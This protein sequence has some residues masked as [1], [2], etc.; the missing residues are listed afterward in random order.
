MA[1]N[2]NW[3]F[4]WTTNYSTTSDRL[5][6]ND[7]EAKLLSPRDSFEEDQ[8]HNSVDD[9]NLSRA[10]ISSSS[11][12]ERQYRV[13]ILTIWTIYAG[14]LLLSMTLGIV[15]LVKANSRN[16]TSVPVSYSFQN[17]TCGSSGEEAV[18]N[19]CIYSFIPG[20]WVP[21]ACHD[22][23]L[24]EEFLGREQWHWYTDK[25]F[26]EEIAMETIRQTGGPPVFYT[27]LDYHFVHCSYTWKKLH[28]AVK[29]QTPIDSHIAHCMMSFS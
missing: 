9:F 21:A 10:T 29:N 25:D 23:E 3:T 14:I 27:N 4:L 15:T 5:T 17:Q 8:Q 26:K 22:T 20:A 28:R 18:R 6:M 24:E 1:H 7:S 2:N 13:K 12:A 19:G 11:D 16:P